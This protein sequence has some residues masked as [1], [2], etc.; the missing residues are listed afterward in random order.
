MSAWTSIHEVTTTYR[1]S[2]PLPLSQWCL[3]LGVVLAYI[4]LAI[5]DNHVLTA[6]DVDTRLDD[7]IETYIRPGCGL[8]LPLSHWLKYTAE[9]LLDYE[10]LLRSRGRSEGNIVAMTH[11]TSGGVDGDVL[12]DW[13]LAHGFD[14][15]GP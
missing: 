10:R 1:V 15:C 12:L 2:P 7:D 5:E 3:N 13:L 14:C 11:D 4:P 9:A 8:F 6:D